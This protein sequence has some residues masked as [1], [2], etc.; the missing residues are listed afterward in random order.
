[1]D[2]IES[3]IIPTITYYSATY[4]RKEKVPTEA[5]MYTARVEIIDRNYTIRSGNNN[6]VEVSFEIRPASLTVIA[7]PV[8]EDIVYG[9]RL[10]DARILSDGRITS[11]EGVVVNGKYTFQNPSFKPNAG[12]NLVNLTFTPYNKN[13]T[14]VNVQDVE[15]YVKRAD[16]EILLNLRAEYDGTNKRHDKICL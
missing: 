2:S 13:F 3:D 16:A 7:K 10:S 11:A 5:G 12:M 9:Q 1:M 8:F 14:P 6:Y 4:S 15:L